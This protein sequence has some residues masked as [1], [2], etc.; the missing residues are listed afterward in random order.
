METLSLAL[1]PPSF[2]LP[3][4]SHYRYL[5]L[6]RAEI[7]V[8]ELFKQNTRMPGTRAR[9]TTRSCGR[10]FIRIGRLARKRVS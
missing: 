7:G 9:L 3:L 8:N 6:P 1:S 2:F 4:P 10:Q 5:A